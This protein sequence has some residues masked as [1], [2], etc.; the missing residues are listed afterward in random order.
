[1]GIV[2]TLRAAYAEQQTLRGLVDEQ[3]V[4]NLGLL[5]SEERALAAAII[6]GQASAARAL[7][8][9]AGMNEIAASNALWAVSQRVP[10][11]DAFDQLDEDAVS[12]P[13]RPTTDGKSKLAF[14]PVRDTVRIWAREGRNPAAGVGKVYAWLF[15]IDGPLNWPLLGKLANRL[16]TEGAALF[17]L[18]HAADNLGRDPL[19]ELFPLAMAIAQQQNPEPTPEQKAEALS[20][21]RASW[22]KRVQRWQTNYPPAPERYSSAEQYEADTRQR[23][24]DLARWEAEDRPAI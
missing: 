8:V 12:A 18:D 16:G 6:A 13:F 20:S 21:E 24:A 10:L 23:A 5:P 22:L 2:D 19:S 17:L 3:V 1:M 4:D 15:G 9:E 7:L 11:W 14:R